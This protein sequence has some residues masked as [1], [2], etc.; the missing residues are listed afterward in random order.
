MCKNE[1]TAMQVTVSCAAMSE[2]NF[3]LLSICSLSYHLLDIFR[4]NNIN[5]KPFS[6]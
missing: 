1:A 3:Y 6:D 2:A 4:V 5:I